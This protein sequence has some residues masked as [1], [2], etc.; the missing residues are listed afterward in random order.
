MFLSGIFCTRTVVIVYVIFSTSFYILNSISWYFSRK[1]KQKKN[2][3]KSGKQSLYEWTEYTQQLELKIK[4]IIGDEQSNPNIFDNMEKLEVNLKQHFNND[5][6]QLKLFKAYLNVDEKDTSTTAL[7]TFL[8]G[9]ISSIFVYLLVNNKLSDIMNEIVPRN[10]INAFNKSGVFY[11]TSAGLFIFSLVLLIVVS[12]VNNTSKNRVRV[13]QE[14]TDMCIKDLEKGLE[15][16]AETEVETRAKAEEKARLK[17]EVR[18]EIESK[19]RLEAEARAKVESE[20]RLKAEV[21]AE[22][23]SEA[24]LEV[25]ARAKVESEARAK[26]EVKEKRWNQIRR[27][28]C[29][30]LRFRRISKKSK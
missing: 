10:M 27:Q 17:A 29:K 15:E 7:Q 1:I 4:E 6:R 16:K 30:H 20:A 23:E 22:V 18:A 5:V 3:K 14:V 24:R 8:I 25:E 11:N 19:A 9:I 2:K 13:F 12:M 28:R 26:A 21:R